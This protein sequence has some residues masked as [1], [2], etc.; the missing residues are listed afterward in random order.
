MCEIAH[1]GFVARRTSHGPCV[2][3]ESGVQANEEMKGRES[4]VF[5]NL[6]EL[7]PELAGLIAVIVGRPVAIVA[8]V[9]LLG[10]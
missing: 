5:C 10:R 8:V 4:G 2:E 7:L 3:L 9:L 6:Y 1:Q